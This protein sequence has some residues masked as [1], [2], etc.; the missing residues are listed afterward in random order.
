MAPDTVSRRAQKN[1]YLGITGSSLHLGDDPNSGALRRDSAPHKVSTLPT[2]PAREHDFPAA[3]LLEFY[4][5]LVVTLCPG[6]PRSPSCTGVVQGWPDAGFLLGHGRSGVPSLLPYREQA[7]GNTTESWR[8]E[9][10]QHARELLWF[11]RSAQKV[12]LAETAT[13]KKGS[14]AFSL[15]QATV[16]ATRRQGAGALCL[17][18]EGRRGEEMDRLQEPPT[19]STWS[20]ANTFAALT[21]GSPSICSAGPRSSTSNSA[22]N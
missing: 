14:I 21:L 16:N 19:T 7:G 2:Q 9:A 8:A 1:P 17:C 4:G 20:C 12:V 11:H 13:G 6:V 18:G 22:E 10:T 15:H 3:R 5:T